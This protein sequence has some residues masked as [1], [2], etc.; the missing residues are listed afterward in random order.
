MSF[1]L[2]ETFEIDSALKKKKKLKMK[3]AGR[4]HTKKSTR[5]VAKEAAIVTK[6][7]KFEGRKAV[8]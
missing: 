4:N 7:Q 2:Q 5:R 1:S 6:E 3:V 8:V